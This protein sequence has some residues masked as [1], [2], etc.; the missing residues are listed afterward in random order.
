MPMERNRCLCAWPGSTFPR[1]FL[2]GVFSMMSVREL[3]LFEPLALNWVMFAISS[4]ERGSDFT[5]GP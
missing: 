3:G 1:V 4:N 5:Q 2:A